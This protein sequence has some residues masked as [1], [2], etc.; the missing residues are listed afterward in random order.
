MPGLL[1]LRRTLPLAFLGAALVLT[2]CARPVTEVTGNIKLR[3]QAPNMTGLHIVFMSTSDGSMHS[4]PIEAD[5]N[6]KAKDVPA[7]EAKVGFMYQPTP[8]G[9]GGQA[10]KSRLAKP[11]A[12]KEAPPPTSGKSGEAA[13]PIPKDLREPGLSNIT[14]N[15]TAGQTNKFDHD[16]K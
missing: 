4:A 1:T 12:N 2:G 11:G 14:F 9:G 15:V 3:G 8:Q 10:T 16:I 7:G 13:N 6:Y 5:G